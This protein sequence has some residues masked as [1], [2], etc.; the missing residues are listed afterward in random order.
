MVNQSMTPMEMKSNINKILL[1]LISSSIILSY[2]SL[3][4]ISTK[5]P[6]ELL[7]QPDIFIVVSYSCIFMT[8]VG[9]TFVSLYSLYKTKHSVYNNKFIT[10]CKHY[11]NKIIKLFYKSLKTLDDFIKHELFINHTG[12]ILKTF[13]LKITQILKYKISKRYLIIYLLCNIIPRVFILFI[14]SIDILYLHKFQY[15]YKVAWLLIIPLLYRYLIFTYKE[16]SEHNINQM[17]QHVLIFKFED[18]S[19][20]NTQDIIEFTIESKSKK[21]SA[22]RVELSKELTQ[23]CYNTG[24]DITQTLAYYLPQFNIFTKLYSIIAIFEQLHKYNIY[25]N[26]IRFL[27][28]SLL[29]LYILIYTEILSIDTF[30][31][32]LNIIDRKEPF[33]GD[34]L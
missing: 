9:L 22:I 29:W 31:F 6:K 21:Y 3:R 25:F 2:I 14:F 27:L 11:A 12:Q 13:G 20:M 4:F 15:V 7:I 24:G 32:L 26:L 18:N 5:L 30:T 34:D 16:F 1:I 17:L 33:S 28:Y 23:I 10:H 8:F 19:I